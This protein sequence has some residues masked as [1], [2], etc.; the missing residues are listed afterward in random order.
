MLGLF[1]DFKPK[2]IKYFGDVGKSVR[3]ALFNYKSE[4]EKGIYPDR[5]HSYEFPRE[6][7]EQI[8]DWFENVDI[9]EEISKTKE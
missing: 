8:N 7:L 5:E 2:F 3:N 1:T 4:V 6:S 9:E